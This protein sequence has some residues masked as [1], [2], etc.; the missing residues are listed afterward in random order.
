[1]SLE[2]LMSIYSRCSPQDIYIACTGAGVLYVH[3][4]HIRT[5]ICIMYVLVY[6]IL[7]A[8]IGVCM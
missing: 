7:M 2:A 6:W 3:I 4:V 5:Y 8:I 1:M